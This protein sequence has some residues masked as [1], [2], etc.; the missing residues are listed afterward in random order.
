MQSNARDKVF[1]PQVVN[2]AGTEAAQ[3]QV[4]LRKALAPPGPSDKRA[5]KRES[6]KNKP[7]L[8]LGKSMFIC[9]HIRSTE[10]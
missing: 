7:Q 8:R 4:W 6:K 5:M 1:R 3:A 10:N 2:R 9:E